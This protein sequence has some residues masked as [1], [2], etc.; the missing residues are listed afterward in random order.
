MLVLNT[1]VNKLSYIPAIIR[2]ESIMRFLLLISL[3]CAQ[4][5]SFG[6]KFVS[7]KEWESAL[8]MTGN[9]LAKIETNY[10]SRCKNILTGSKNIGFSQ[11]WQDWFLYRNFFAGKTDGVY[12]DIG[13]V[14]S[15]ES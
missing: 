10:Q 6:W 12:L 5:T 8:Q 7:E 11:S 2:K 1:L 9:L 13:T 14:C 4:H 15:L 3:M